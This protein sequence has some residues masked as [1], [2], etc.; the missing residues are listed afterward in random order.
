[1]RQQFYFTITVLIMLLDLSSYAQARITNKKELTID[2]TIRSEVDKHISQFKR[3]ANSNVSYSIYE[4][5]KI[6]KTSNALGEPGLSFSSFIENTTVINCLNGIEEGI[7]FDLILSKDTTLLR[8][9]LVSALNEESLRQGIPPE[10]SV[11]C[12]SYKIVLADKP[13][14]AKGELVVGKIELESDYF[15]IMVGEE[16]R[17]LKC[18]SEVYFR[19][20]PLPIKD[21]KYL[22]LDKKK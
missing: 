10:I 22:T 8:F 6:I 7:G 2:T 5:D 9:K 18:K 12:I 20:E 13:T 1:M 3:Q 15:Y 4:G 17:Q 21:G 14:F 11:E 16:K 19:S